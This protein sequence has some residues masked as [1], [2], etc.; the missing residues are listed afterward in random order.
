MERGYL[1]IL[2]GAVILALGAFTAFRF[3]MLAYLLIMGGLHSMP[4]AAKELKSANIFTVV[5]LVLSLLF[6]WGPRFLWTNIYINSLLATIQMFFSIGIFFW[7]FKAEYM[8]SPKSSTRI[9]WL[10]YSVVSLVYLVINALM[11]FPTISFRILPIN[12]MRQASNTLELIDMLYYATLI[13]ILAKLY[14]DARKNRP[15]FQR[16]D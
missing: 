4:T 16:W 12:L 1:V 15:G 11:L 5:A 7:L 2:V 10:L 8:W 9:D 6:A 13:F 14:L 3:P